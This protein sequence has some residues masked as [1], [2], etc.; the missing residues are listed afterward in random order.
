MLRSGVYLFREDGMRRILV[1]IIV[2]STLFPLKITLADTERGI[3]IL[4]PFPVSVCMQPITHLLL[5]PCF[6]FPGGPAHLLEAPSLDPFYIDK[7]V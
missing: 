7:Y 4:N 3:L 5:D 1:L 6:Q 2:F